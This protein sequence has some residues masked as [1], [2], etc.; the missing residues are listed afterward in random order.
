MKTN[1]IWTLLFFTDCLTVEYAIKAMLFL[2][3]CFYVALF[4]LHRDGDELFLC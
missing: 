2:V 4:M 3:V 1:E